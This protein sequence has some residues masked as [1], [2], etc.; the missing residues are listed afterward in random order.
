MPGFEDCV[1]FVGT[2]QS[3]FFLTRKVFQDFEKLFGMI[4][5]LEIFVGSEEEE[6]DK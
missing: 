1:F 5:N 3:K 6:L 2:S 4:P